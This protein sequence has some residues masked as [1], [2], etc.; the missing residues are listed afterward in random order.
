MKD[1]LVHFH[2]E[3]ESDLSLHSESALSGF[4]PLQTVVEGNSLRRTIS[5]SEPP[6]SPS[7]I[8][9]LK[10]S[11]DHSIIPNVDAL[12][13]KYKSNNSKRVADSILGQ[14]K[15]NISGASDHEREE[16]ELARK[17]QFTEKVFQMWLAEVKA[18][19][20]FSNRP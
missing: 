7:T 19:I 8:S 16:K 1:H 18:Q 3:E 14:H 6:S 20:L 17:R 9:S 5:P 12:T 2:Y 10:I 4:L 13:N 15:G 11:T